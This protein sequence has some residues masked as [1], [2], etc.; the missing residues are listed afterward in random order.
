[1][2]TARL[3][4]ISMEQKILYNLINEIFTH[5]KTKQNKYKQKT[6]PLL[7]QKSATLTLALLH[8]NKTNLDLFVTDKW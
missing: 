7:T 5:K 1:M 4:N 8:A 6:S 2:R 3:S